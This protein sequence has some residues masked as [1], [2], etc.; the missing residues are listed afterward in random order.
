[1]LQCGALES[2]NKRHHSRLFDHLGWVTSNADGAISLRCGRPRF[3]PMIRHQRYGPVSDNGDL[4]T[5][6]KQVYSAGP[7][8][9]DSIRLSEC[10]WG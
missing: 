10:C 5:S 2:A 1:M 7:L 9:L 8:F 4:S 3:R 6:P